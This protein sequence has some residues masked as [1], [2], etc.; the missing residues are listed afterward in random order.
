[1]RYLHRFYQATVAAV[2]VVAL[3]AGATQSRAAE[4]TVPYIRHIQ[5]LEQVVKASP[6][7]VLL[8]FDATW[9]AYCRALQP[10]IQKLYE[11]TSPEVLRIYKIDMDA[12][13]ALAVE[14][15]VQ[16]LPTL[17]VIRGEEAVA[18]KRGGMDEAQLF[19]WIDS[20]QKDMAP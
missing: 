19:E 17:F 15:G 11:T 4:N 5:E 16:A 8:Q 20:V 9:C 13:P 2:C 10:H 7:P 3:L 6:V 18:F 1:M 14:F 12:S